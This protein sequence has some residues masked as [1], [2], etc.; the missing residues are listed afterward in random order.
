MEEDRV[1]LVL[2]LLP[3]LSGSTK[4]MRWSLV[5]SFVGLVAIG[6]FLLIGFSI[7]SLPGIEFAV[8]LISLS[9]YEIER[10]PQRLQVLALHRSVWTASPV[11]GIGIGGLKAY[12]AW[13]TSGDLARGAHN[14]TIG[15]AA[16]TGLVGLTVVTLIGIAIVRRSLFNLK[17]ELGRWLPLAIGLAAAFIAQ[18][19]YG[20]GHDIRGEKHLWLVMAL[21]VAVYLAYRSGDH[22][23]RVSDS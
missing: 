17:R 21:I 18:Q 6:L 2:L 14:A 13:L 7:T 20:L 12:T 1:G 5:L 22:E 9:G 4:W 3:R 19:V 10:L 8:S 15:V 16:E 11:F 23:P